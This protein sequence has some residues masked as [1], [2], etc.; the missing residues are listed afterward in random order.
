[1][2]KERF[3]EDMENWYSDG[4]FRKDLKISV[5]VTGVR[6]SYPSK[7][8]IFSSSRRTSLSNSHIFAAII[9]AIDEMNSFFLPSSR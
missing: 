2:S 5:D 8:L 9:A 7:H 1:M 4:P 6:L 3:D